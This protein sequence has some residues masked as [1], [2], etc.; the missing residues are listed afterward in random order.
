MN[1]KIIY[2]AS[3][4]TMGSM[5]DVECNLYR[6]WA[7]KELATEYPDFD[8]EVSSQN[9]SDTIKIIGDEEIDADSVRDFVHRLWDRGC[10]EAFKQ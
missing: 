7:E 1:K 2:Y 10:T 9:Y 5:S 6:A 3:N 4:N 8:T